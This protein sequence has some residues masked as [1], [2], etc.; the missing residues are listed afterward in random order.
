MRAFGTSGEEVA[1]AREAGGGGLEAFRDAPGP[2]PVT[3]RTPRARSR[4]PELPPPPPG[5]Q[6]ARGR[7]SQL[8]AQPGTAGP[9]RA[10]GTKLS[11]FVYPAPRRRQVADAGSASPSPWHLA[12]SEPTPGLPSHSGGHRG[13]GQ[14]EEGAAS[15]GRVEAGAT[16]PSTGDFP[17]VH[18]RAH[19]GT[20][21]GNLP[22][23]PGRTHPIGEARLSPASVLPPSVPPSLPPPARSSRRRDWGEGGAG[24]AV[25]EPQKSVPACSR[26]K[27]GPDLGPGPGRGLRE[28]AGLPSRAGR[29]AVGGPGPG[30]GRGRGPALGPA[31]TPPS[32]PRESPWRTA[33]GQTRDTGHA[34]HLCWGLSRDCYLFPSRPVSLA[35]AHWLF[36][37]S[38]LWV[39]LDTTSLVRTR[40]LLHPPHLCV[41]GPL[42]CWCSGEPASLGFSAML[43]GLLG[44][45]VSKGRTF[46]LGHVPGLQDF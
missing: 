9:Q 17:C 45:S 13:G 32:S 25:S 35:L 36:P 6:A 33:T 39:S 38:F 27:G 4:V 22:P 16:Q 21:R 1:A 11:A 31:A 40:L 29:A 20:A 14:E 3:S 28:G 2:G 7:L 24:R 5:L 30:P 15:P 26:P 44:E 41:P 10:P 18:T 42:C 34:E 43:S 19:T 12:L 23:F 8:G 46:L 37:S